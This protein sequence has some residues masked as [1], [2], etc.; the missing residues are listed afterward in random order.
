MIS[1]FI[2]LL[3]FA[4]SPCLTSL[5]GLLY[6][7]KAYALD[8]KNSLYANKMVA[9]KVPVVQCALQAAAK[10]K[11]MTAVNKEGVLVLYN[12]WLCKFHRQT[13]VSKN[14]KSQS[15]WPVVTTVGF[16]IYMLLCELRNAW[17]DGMFT[18]V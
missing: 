4:D 13:F 1:H 14:S 8:R 17:A 2:L 5:W 12:L 11:E 18:R 16:A 9:L 10:L 15:N 7:W 6:S 3:F